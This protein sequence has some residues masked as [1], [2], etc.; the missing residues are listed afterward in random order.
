MLRITQVIDG[1]FRGWVHKEDKYTV[2]AGWKERQNLRGGVIQ[3]ES[4]ACEGEEREF[5]HRKIEIIE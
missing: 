1:E 4:F 3:F 5:F 2:Q